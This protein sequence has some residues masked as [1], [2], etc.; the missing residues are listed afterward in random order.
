MNIILTNDE[1]ELILYCMEQ[2]E[3]EFNSEEQLICNSIFDK[4]TTAQA[5]D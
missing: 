1:I 4:F 2:Q 3:Y 5:N